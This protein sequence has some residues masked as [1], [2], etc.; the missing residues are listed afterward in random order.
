MR[1]AANAPAL[2]I[3]D[4]ERNTSRRILSHHPAFKAQPLEALSFCA[5][6]TEYFTVLHSTPQY[7]V[8]TALAAWPLAHTA[9]LGL[10][11]F[12]SH[13]GLHCIALHGT[14]TG[15]AL[16]W[17]WRGAGVAWDGIALAWHGTPCCAGVAWHA[18][19]CFGAPF[20][21]SHFGAVRTVRVLAVRFG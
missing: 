5:K 18:V 10:G 14:G 6:P 7:T 20:G 15:P 21:L 11:P 3:Y 9:V 17:H 13:I 8:Y 2:I 16:K 1:R 19:L 12:R 4:I